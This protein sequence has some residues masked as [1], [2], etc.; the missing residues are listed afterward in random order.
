MP[1][2]KK[3][4]VTT[5]VLTIGAILLCA[6]IVL[7]ALHYSSHQKGAAKPSNGNASTE[8]PSIKTLPKNWWESKQAIYFDIPARILIKLPG[9]DEKQAKKVFYKAWREF[10][11]IGQIFNP[12]D[13]DTEVA[14]IN[15]QS[16]NGW[17]EVSRDLYQV[18]KI[19]RNLWIESNGRF[20]PTFL[21]I[22]QLWRHAEKTQNIP[23]D[24]EILKTLQNT[25]LSY[26]AL[27]S[28]A[29]NK[30]RIKNP[31]LQFDFGGIAKGYAVDQ[32]RQLLKN[33]GAADGLV[34]LGG[35]VAAFGENDDA[36]WRIGIQHP[37]N[38]GDVWGII[39]HCSGIRVSTSGN[40][41]QPLIIRGQ[42]FYHIFSPATGKPVPEKVLGVTTVGL[43]ASHSNAFL[44]GAA[45]AITAMGAQKGIKFA[46]KLGIEALI[47]TQGRDRT[48]NEIM[49]AGC[50]EIYHGQPDAH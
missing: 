11:R 9:A 12:F 42:P 35:E 31:E 45:T 25:G 18:I 43:S 23:S 14:D 32:V 15:R 46:E 41:R 3:N 6:G 38:M 16:A 28:E 48:I 2:L 47:L 40:Y 30:I 17:V 5:A 36:P 10:E 37:K 8:M 39:R 49:T 20:D 7:S 1:K 29:S 33:S 26:V 4:Y 22:K 44:D 27:K 24:R 19:S 34:Q 50:R 21:P 13:P